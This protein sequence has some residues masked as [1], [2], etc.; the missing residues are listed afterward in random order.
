VFSTLTIRR[1]AAALLAAGFALPALGDD[2]VSVRTAPMAAVAIYPE[3]SAPATVVSLNDA[4]ISAQLDARVVE[5]PVRVGDT[6][7]A[8]TLLARLEC[9]D[10]EALQVRQL[11]ALEATEARLELARRRVE[12]TGKLVDR[13]S[14]AE[15]LFDERSADVAVLEAERKS[16][17]KALYQANTDVGRCELTSPFRAVILERLGAVGGFASKGTPLLRILD[18]DNIEISA[19]VATGDTAPLSAAGEIFLEHAEQRYPVSIR[20]V[21]PT[22]NTETR[23]REVRLLFTAESAPPGAAGELVWTDSRPH[24]PGELLVRRGKAFGVFAEIG[25]IARFIEVPAAQPGRASLAPIPAD[26]HVVI[27][28]HFSLQDADPVS[29]VN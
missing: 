16:A 18:L 5:I 13:Q 26:T 15:D 6:V 2:P 1:C 7:E 4:R 17:S 11:A 19:Q 24:V 9:H 20:T 21:L 25:G 12:R 10:F 23:N 8:G 22:V 28:G 29:V 14:A 27:E 3:R